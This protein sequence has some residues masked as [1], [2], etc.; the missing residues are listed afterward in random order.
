MS[1]QV[2]AAWS[3]GSGYRAVVQSGNPDVAVRFAHATHR[4]NGIID[5]RLALIEPDRVV[6]EPLIGGEAEPDLTVEF[7]LFRV[8]L[9][10]GEVHPDL[11]DLEALDLAKWWCSLHS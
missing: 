6:A 1:L 11:T 4:L 5:N 2:F 3:R 10:N 9:S 8:K 7:D